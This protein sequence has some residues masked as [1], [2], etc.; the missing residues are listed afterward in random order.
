MKLLNTEDTALTMGSDENSNDAEKTA[1]KKIKQSQ[2]VQQ[3]K[4]QKETMTGLS[5][6]MGNFNII[7]IILFL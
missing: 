4:K 2:L 7:L 6:S 3:A 5:H 1:M